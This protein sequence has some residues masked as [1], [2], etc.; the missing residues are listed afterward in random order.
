[1]LKK[2]IKAKLQLLCPADCMP[3]PELNQPEAFVVIRAEC[4]SCGWS[5]QTSY[6]SGDP[7][8]EQMMRSAQSDLEQLH[9]D[10]YPDCGS[11][12]RLLK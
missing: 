3:Y 12:I 10:E 2:N 7:H 11:T 5:G 6:R 8:P 4:N 1:M 9:L